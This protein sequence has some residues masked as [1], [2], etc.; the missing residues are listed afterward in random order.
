[1]ALSESG[2]SPE[3]RALQP[4]SCG[5]SNQAT[6]EVEQVE[7]VGKDHGRIEVRNHTVS[8]VVDWIASD[9]SYPGAPRF[10]KLTTIGMV[11][12]RIERGDK[13]RQEIFVQCGP[14]G[15]GERQAALLA[16]PAV[17]RAREGEIARWIKCAC[18]QRRQHRDR[19]RCLARHR[20]PASTSR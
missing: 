15:A 7:T 3:G 17:A 10:P 8:H 18:E 2:L 13:I 14:R 4:S 5:A 9:R 6:E 16:R 11:E 20:T 1:M 19:D 12:S